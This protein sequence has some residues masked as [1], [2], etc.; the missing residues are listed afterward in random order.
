[1]YIFFGFESKNDYHMRKSKKDLYIS[2][3]DTV[4]VYKKKVI[5]ESQDVTQGKF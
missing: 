2:K 5:M 4:F 3:K 1:M